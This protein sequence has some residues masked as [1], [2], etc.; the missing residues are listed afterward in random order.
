MSASAAAARSVEEIVGGAAG[1]L[2]GAPDLASTLRGIAAAARSALGADR[3]TCY[4]HDVEAQVISAVYSTEVDPERR[5][6]LERAVGRGTARLP[7]LRLQLAQPD[8]LL[9]IEDITRDPTVPPALAARLGSGALI[10]ARLEHL[11]VGGEGPPALLGTLFCSYV[12][13]RRF[14]ASERQAAYGLANLAALALANA[15]LQAETARILAAASE[16]SA[17]FQRQRDYS[18]ALV[19]SMR[20]GLTVLSPEGTVIEVSPSF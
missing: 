9:A 11:S 20:D 2:S 5:A 15:R 18:A 3:A 14:S 6:F 13:P 8:P 7:I 1:R 4:V 19:A 16:A 12:R 10:G 17:A